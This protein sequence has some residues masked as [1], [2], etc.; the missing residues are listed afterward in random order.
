MSHHCPGKLFTTNESELKPHLLVVWIMKQFKSS[1]N[2]LDSAECRIAVGAAFHAFT[3]NQDRLDHAFATA[4]LF[5]ASCH[6]PQIC[7]T[8]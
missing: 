1:G 8:G 3:L 2:F 7:G 6:G 5:T 4:T